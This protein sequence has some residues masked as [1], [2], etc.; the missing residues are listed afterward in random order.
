M[1]KTMTELIFY[2]NAHNW[3]LTGNK[4]IEKNKAYDTDLTA[5]QCKSCLKQYFKHA[6]SA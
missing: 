4:I 3:W 1:T 6:I 2:K 5:I